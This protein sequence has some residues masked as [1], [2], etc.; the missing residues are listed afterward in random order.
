MK[1]IRVANG[2][3]FWG[4]CIEAPSK[5]I[6]YGNSDYLT[7]DYL[8]EV[9][10]SIMQRQK[11]KDPENG[12]Y[13]TD[14]V[15]LVDSNINEIINNNIKIIA[16]AGGVNPD[17]CK[18][19]LIKISKKHDIDLKIAIVEGDDIYNDLNNLIKDDHEFKNI[20]TNESISSILTKIYSANVYIDSFS[21]AKALSLGADIVL[22]GRIS[23]P[24]L[25]VAPCIYEF[26]WEKDN[27]NMLASATVA[28]HIIECGAQCTGGNFTKW[29]DLKDM[30]N[31]GYPI[32]QIRED[33]TFD[34]TKPENTGGLV[35]KFTVSE[36]ILYELGD[37]KK[38]ISP[39]VC[40]DFTS[41]NLEETSKDVVTVTGVKGNMPTDT[42]KVSISYF[43]GF[44]ASG[45]LT[46][47]GPDA[48]LKAKKSA[49][50]IWK[51]LEK[52]GL[53]FDK[54]STEFLGLSSCHKSIAKTPNIINEVVLRL[55]VKSQDKN[56]VTRFTK[57]LAPL[58]T[59]GP[60]GITG[61]AGGRPRVKEVVA[62]WP[63]LIDKKVIKT[64]VIL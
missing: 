51:K 43:D 36:Q 4:D 64:K 46:V 48:L 13:A 10:M 49:E 6:K 55:G 57:E 59:A 7:L 3:G 40:V 31:I 56:I 39:D 38:Y 11:K 50:I 23:D 45:Q 63:A 8:A 1:N 61:F 42:Y 25:V 14:F 2:Q 54:T 29:K 32:A 41:F 52:I 37:P 19:E 20:D 9:T 16:N 17:A 21:V 34:I 62:Y 60:P 35:N 47:S 5:L 33:G 44:K 58:I 53:V 30:D 12:G 28:G 18:R 24:G 27:F 26:G 22:C 15:A